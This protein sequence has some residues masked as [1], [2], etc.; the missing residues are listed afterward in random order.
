MRNLPCLTVVVWHCTRT[1][2]TVDQKLRGVP[3]QPLNPKRGAP[4]SCMQ[5]GEGD[6]S[7]RHF[8]DTVRP[9]P[10]PGHSSTIIPPPVELEAPQVDLRPATGSRRRVEARKDSFEAHRAASAGVGTHCHLRSLV[11]GCAG[12]RLALVIS[13]L[14]SA[15]ARRVVLSVRGSLGTADTGQPPPPSGR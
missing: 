15:T 3:H 2:G 7:T 6:S 4:A 8:P 14:P 13:A 12:K 9:T 1:K 11:V 10:P 5:E